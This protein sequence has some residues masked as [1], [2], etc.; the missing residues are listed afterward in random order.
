VLLQQFA[1]LMKVKHPSFSL[2]FPIHVQ[3][4]PIWATCV[5]DSCSE[6]QQSDQSKD[7][8]SGHS[9]HQQNSHS[10]DQ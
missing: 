1:S 8:Q 10:K 5:G 9:K 4:K 3:A 2:T 7:Q 6:D